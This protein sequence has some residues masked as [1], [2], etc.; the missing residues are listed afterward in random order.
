M[1]DNGKLKPYDYQTDTILDVEDFDGRSL[2]SLDMGTGKTLITLWTLQRR[3]IKSFPA[4]IVCPATV[5]YIWEREAMRIGFRPTVLEGQKPKEGRNGKPP[6]ITII[7]YDIL[8]Y[9]IPYLLDRGIGT[10]VLD[11]C[12]YLLS[13]QSKR[14]RACVLLGRQAKHVIA[15]SG[16]PL[17]NRPS[18]LW[19]TLHILRPDLYS[20]FWKF[21]HAYCNPKRTRWGWDYKGASN[22]DKLHARLCRTLMIRKKKEDVLPDLPPKMRSVVPVEIK[23]RKQYEHAANNFISWLKKYKADKVESAKRAEQITKI[24]YLLR[25]CARLKLKSVVNWCNDFLENNDE[26]LVV[27]CIHRK[28]IEA[29][30]RRVGGG[31]H[32]II[33]GSVTGRKRQA[34]IDQFQNDPKTRVCIGNV[35]AAGV[36]IT[37]TA[38]STVAFAE[39]YWTPGSMTQAEDRCYRIGQTSTVWAYYLTAKNTIEERLAKVIQEKQEVIQSVLDGGPVGDDMDIFDQ[40]LAELDKDKPKLLK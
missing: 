22:L 37:L 17:V 9:W 15:L 14:T 28:M 18:E 7:N 16:T 38:A 11:E 35:K 12:H 29:L 19:P 3:N 27:F 24:G 32:S 6:R 23:D 2:V 13:R 4:V 30:N 39:L 21:A 25:L 40:L 33:D 34:A 20:S 10:L 1:T 5:K 31:K 8:Q 26:K 36:G